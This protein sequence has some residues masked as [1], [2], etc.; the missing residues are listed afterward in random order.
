[1]SSR[2]FLASQ[3]SFLA[4]A[5]QVAAKFV[6]VD[7]VLSLC[8][9]TFGLV[10]VEFLS[11]RDCFALQVSSLAAFC[12]VAAKFLFCLILVLFLFSSCLVW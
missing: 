5:C 3:V 11:S 1:M 7:K 4:V 9:S 6:F 12:Q 2:D 10:V 8:L